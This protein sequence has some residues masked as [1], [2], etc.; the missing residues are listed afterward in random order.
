MR[1]ESKDVHD[2]TG[3][4]IGLVTSRKERLEQI[5]I[6]RVDIALESAQLARHPAFAVQ[7]EPPHQLNL[8][9]RQRVCSD[10]LI[11]M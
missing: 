5:T 4:H 9:Q 2:E 7:L 6:N 3:A 8:K 1:G 11:F 10:M